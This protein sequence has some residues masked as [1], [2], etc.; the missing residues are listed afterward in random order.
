MFT[1]VVVALVTGGLIYFL[2]RKNKIQ[3]LKTEDGWWGAGAPSSGGEDVTIRPFKVATSDEELEDLY[4]RIDQTRPV[5]SLEDSQFNYGFNSQYLQKV[6]SYWR[7]DFDWRRQV[8]KINQYPHFK[9]N[10]EGIDIHYL[11]VKPKKVPEGTTVIP[12][13]MV[14][15]WPGSFYE[16]YG[17]IPLLTEPSDP[18]DLVFEVVCPSIPGYGFSEAPHKKGF[19]SV[20][21]ARI[22]HKLMRRLGFQQFY[23]HGGDWGWLVTTNMAQLEPTTVNGLHVNFAPPSKPTLPI[24]L[25]IMLGRRFPKLFGFTDIDIQRLFPPTE[26]LV[27]ESIKESG[28]MH[29]QATKPDTVGRGLNDSPVGLAAYILEKFSTWT[30]SDFRSLEDGGVT[31]KFSLDDL[32]TNVMIYWTSGCIISSMRF[33]KENFGQGLDAPH[34]KIPVCVPTGFACFPNELMHSP[35]LWVK[36]NYPKLVSYTPMARG[37]HFAAM[38]EPQLMAEDIQ[39]FIKTVEKKK[40]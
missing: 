10:I 37:G 26:K 38:E 20:C 25:S 33:Y 21:A 13:I 2:L 6:V 15:G 3:V 40:K 30:S 32:L 8:D 19:D 28:Y 34:T 16:F 23:A 1:E 39:N 5:P 11:H 36:Q 27:V 12:L 9:T 31:R 29:I 14:H 35:K 4:R 7:N 18:G 17:L 24:V 22:F